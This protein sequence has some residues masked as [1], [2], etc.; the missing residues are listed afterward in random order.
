MRIFWKSRSLRGEC[1]ES[2][3]L[4]RAMG[5]KR[6][7]GRSSQGQ[8]QDCVT[9]SIGKTK[10]EVNEEFADSEDEF[11]AERDKI[12]LEEGLTTNRRENLEEEGGM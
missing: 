12:L 2:N 5:E 7:V 4:Y 10:Y 11:F 6:K 9:M 1:S 3:P 8:T